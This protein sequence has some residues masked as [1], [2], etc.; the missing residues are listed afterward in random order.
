LIAWIH[1]HVRGAE[2]SFSSIDNHTQHAYSKLH[3]GVLGLVIEI[4]PDGKRGVYDFFELS[5]FGKQIIERCNRSKHCITT[6]QHDS[7]MGKKFYQSAMG[8]V[9]FDDF[10]TLNVSNFISKETNNG[11]NQPTESTSEN[12][13][14]VEE[15]S[16]NSIGNQENSNVSMSAGER[17]EPKKHQLGNKIN[18]N[19]CKKSF[20]NLFSHLSR[21]GDCRAWYGEEFDTMKKEREENVNAK[22]RNRERNR[23][24]QNP[25]KKRKESAKNYA[26]KKEVIRNSQ[27]AYKSKNAD[28]IKEDHRRYNTSNAAIIAEKQQV[29]RKKARDNRTQEDRFHYFCQ[30]TIDGPNFV[31]FSCKRTLFKRGVKVITNNEIPKLFEKIGVDF[32][33]TIGLHSH[34]T[35]TDLILCHNC[36]SKIKKK[37]VPNIHFSN[38]LELDDIPDELKI[39]DLEQQLIAKTLIFLKV[40]KLPRG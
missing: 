33:R 2:C 4:L 12:E 11:Q 7:C 25:A 37:K 8:K 5:R 30:G 14:E 27:K 24:S 40:K 21:S 28:H 32:L 15:M 34:D 26:E 1:S 3:S 9:S 23:Y 18:C 31:C 36:L 6:V 38:G 29:R 20:V 13:M 19:Y 10:Y 22:K 16:K 35:T 17:M 39:S